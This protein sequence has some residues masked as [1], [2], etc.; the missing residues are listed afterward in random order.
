M[1]GLAAPATVAQIELSDPVTVTHISVADFGLD[2]EDNIAPA[3]VLVRLHGQ[4]IG[5]VLVDAPGGRVDESTCAKVA[6]TSLEEEISE[7]LAIDGL[8]FEAP[9]AARPR[10]ARPQCEQQAA[11]LPDPA[12]SVTVVVSTRERQ[13]LLATCLDAL[14]ELDYPNYDVIVVDNAPTTDLTEQL[15]AN[16]YPEVRYVREDR[17]GLAAAHNCALREVTGSIMAITDDDVRVDRSWLTETVR[18]FQADTDVACVTGL[19]LPMELQTKAQ[20]MLEAHGHFSKGYQQRVFDLKDN[21]PGDEPLFPFAAGQFGSGANMSFDTAKLRAIGG[22][23]QATGT[24]TV[25]RGGDDLL[26]FFSILAKGHRLVYQP[27]AMVWH[28]HR[29]DLESLSNQAYGYGVGLGAYAASAIAAHPA[30]LGQAIYRMP[31]A[32]SYVFRSDSPRSAHLTESDWPRELSRLERKGLAYGPIAYGISRWRT[33]GSRGGAGT[34]TVPK[35]RQPLRS[36][37]L[38]GRVA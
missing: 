31:T 25:A 12:P 8:P 5:T 1:S 37:K 17:P 35:P 14:R 34:A 29:R 9:V 33:R 3:V 7:H 28:R 23:D 20:V 38:S 26:A 2:S 16:K 24:G 36:G 15:I 19:I 22:F 32:L 11:P 27:A 10:D 30:M 21:R 4:P 13:A 6:W 18:A